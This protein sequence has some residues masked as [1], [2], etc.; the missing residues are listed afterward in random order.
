[1]LD[2]RDPAFQQ[3]YPYGCH[4]YDAWGRPIRFVQ[5]C[6]PE[7]GEVIRMVSA[8]NGTALA[9]NVSGGPWRRHGF[10]PAPLRVVANRPAV[11]VARVCLHMD[12]AVDQLRGLGASA[13]STTEAIGAFR[14][15]MTE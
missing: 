12:Q 11:E 3:Q 8:I 9:S 7:T 10:W 4:V 14:D 1:M 15:A 6:N 2:A 5:A 13:A